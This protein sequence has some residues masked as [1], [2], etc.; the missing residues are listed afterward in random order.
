MALVIQECE[1]SP[2]MTLLLENLDECQ[3]NTALMLHL[4]VL[5]PNHDALFTRINKNLNTT[6]IYDKNTTASLLSSHV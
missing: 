3:K 4:L 2:V 5:Q 1:P 6:M